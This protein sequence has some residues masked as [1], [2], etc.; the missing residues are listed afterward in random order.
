MS[1]ATRTRP[2]VPQANRLHAVLER[3]L[4]RARGRIRAVDCFNSLLVLFIA[5]LGYTLLLVCLDHWL[6]LS[7][8]LRQVLLLGFGAAA[9][10]YAVYSL[11]VPMTRHVNAYYA[12]RALERSVPDAK[13]GLVNW[14]DLRDEPLSP[15]IRGA[16]Q[17]RAVEELKNADIDEAIPIRSPMRLFFACA[18]LLLVLF[19]LGITWSDQIG[20]LLHRALLPFDLTNIPT[21]TRIQLTHPV[22]DDL[23][24]QPGNAPVLEIS[25]EPGV[26]VPLSAVVHGSIPQSMQVEYQ[27]TLQE[28]AQRLPLVPPA[29]E[30]EGLPWAI[31]L[32]AEQ[33]PADGLWFRLRGGDGLTRQFRLVVASRLPPSV[34]TV[35]ATYE[36]PKYTRRPNTT[37]NHAPLKAIIGTKVSL[38][39]EADQPVKAGFLHVAI[40]GKP[41]QTSALRVMVDR[42]NRLETTQPIELTAEM[43]KGTT[44]RVE[45]HAAG[46]SVKPGFSEPYPIEIEDDLAP[47][48][49]IKQIG[50]ELLEPDQ[51]VV[52]LHANDVVSVRGYARDDIELRKVQLRLRGHDERELRLLNKK[53]EE[54][55]FP[56]Q[57][58]GLSPERVEYQVELDLTKVSDQLRGDD[59]RPIELKPG[60]VLEMWVEALDNHE[61]QPNIGKSRIIKIELLEPQD[62]DKRKEQEKEAQ[63]EQKQHEQNQE[64]KRQQEQPQQEEKPDKPE[65]GKPEPGKP[66]PGKPEPGKPEPGKPEPG[67]PEPGKPEPGKPESGKP[68]PGKPEPGKPEPGKPEPGKPEP[69]KPEP[70]KPE[71][72]KP[73]PQDGDPQDAAD[74][75][76]QLAEAMKKNTQQGG[77]DPGP[78]TTPDQENAEHKAKATDLLLEKF[79]DKLAK[80]EI[81]KDLKKV[82]D[83][84]KMDEKQMKD[85]L[86]NWKRMRE[87]GQIKDK[88]VARALDNRENL[89]GKG[90]REAATRGSYSRNG[91]IDPALIP[92][93][94]LQGAAEIFSR[95]QAEPRSSRK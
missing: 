26:P 46:A 13:N 6:H 81:D 12:A 82:M 73:E 2:P 9:G 93:R 37:K 94:E 4:T 42:P 84:M 53:T 1:T 15:V 55:N 62:Q 85:F 54:T 49:E 39:I 40:P 95:K 38:Q 51:D 43:Q 61:P 24:E 71:P 60:Q 36:Y 16:V 31:T 28:H 92:P 5:A 89:M 25:V 3:E 77:G 7:N 68:E 27:Y 69:G 20:S 64:N 50:K 76:A 57:L 19:F 14:L 56:G 8:G 22:K 78:K 17:E 23:W 18:G 45:M 21:K 75:A 44:Y 29:A 86:A 41:A 48:V 74:K 34:S 79:S 88:D 33:I 72:G 63:Q 10:A 90:P 65:A 70:G 47:T 67:K 91:A 35:E 30:E 11:V 66:E 52:Q 32:P 58:P 87:S 83:E 59:A 80:G